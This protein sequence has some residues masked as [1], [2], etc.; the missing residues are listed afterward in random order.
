[1]PFSR[2]VRERFAACHD[3]VLSA[4][5]DDAM[6]SLA[7]STRKLHGAIAASAMT[8]TLFAARPCH[9]DSTALSWTRAEG[10]ESC[11]SREASLRELEALLRRPL[12]VALE[13]RSL[14]IVLRRQTEQ[15]TAE[16]FWRAPDGALLAAQTLRSAE[17]SCAVFATATLT[18]AMVALVTGVHP[19]A[20]P[21]VTRVEPVVVPP[22]VTPPPPPVARPSPPPPP[23]PP[24]WTTGDLAIGA[25]AA[26]YVM[27]PLNGGMQI[28]GEP[29]VYRRFRVGASVTALAESMLGLTVLAS[30]SAV[31][32]GAD[33]CVGVTP[34][35]SRFGVFPCVGARAG[36]IA[37]FGYDPGVPT[38][39]TRG[40]FA[41]H[42]S[43]LLRADIRPIVLS[44]DSAFRW[45]MTRYA[46]RSTAGATLVEQSPVGFT[47]TFRIGIAIR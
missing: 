16:L 11:P 7:R 40:S 12:A 37:G 45:N 14:E 29:F 34:E 26:V 31:E 27:P 6:S 25:V 1:V 41:A 42:A 43:L 47:M 4:N 33:G 23:P 3:P 15:W 21:S 19:N 2:A 9:A 44:L 8:V 30:F 24:R 18:S 28:Y 38:G 32:F 46:L 17:P 35:H 39:G 10:A 5:I 22:A 20:A 13:G 36:A